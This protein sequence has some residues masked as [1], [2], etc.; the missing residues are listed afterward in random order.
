MINASFLAVDLGASS[1]R[2]M[3]AQ[4]NGEKATLEEVHRFHNGG[5]RVGN[6]LFWNVLGIWSGILDGLRRYKT[7]AGGVPSGIGIDAWGVDFAL[8]DKRGRMMGNAVHY[9]DPRTHGMV[10]RIA[11]T[12]SSNEMYQITGVQPSAINTAC[13]LVSMVAED[14]EIL[15]LAST[16]LM[17]PDLFQYLLSGVKRAEFTEATTSQLYAL[18]DKGWAWDLVDRLEIPRRIFP[19]LCRPGTQLGPVLGSVLDDCGFTETF[20]AIA[21][22]SHDTASA[23][24]AIPDMDSESAFLSCGTWSL[25]GAQVKEPCGADALRLGFTHE[26]SADGGLLCMRNLTGLWILQECV[27]CWEAEGRSYAWEDLQVAAERAD[28]FQALI[29]TEAQEFQV[30][31]KMPLT[32]AA[33]CSA[34]GQIAPRT[35]GETTRCILE[36]L[37]LT[38]RRT[39]RDLANVTGRELRTVRLVGGGAKNR[40]LCRMTAGACGCTVVAGPVEAAALGNVLVQAVATGHFASLQEGASALSAGEILTRFEARGTERWAEAEAQLETVRRKR[41]FYEGK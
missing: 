14:D 4:W 33:W 37:S 1:G 41:Q 29:D 22:A 3:A 11:E 5:V 31:G 7:Q 34:T 20:P 32:I 36:S 10:E 28:P 6:G 40:L 30:L 13:Q 8:L 2:V 21:V 39:L 12:I 16:L 35:P 18:R 19:E 15:K 25:M 38:Y 17:I 24:A 9:R 26:G 27:R 23:A